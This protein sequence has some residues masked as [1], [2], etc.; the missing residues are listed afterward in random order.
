MTRTP[1]ASFPDDE[2]LVAFVDGR[3]DAAR[4]ATV[5]QRLSDDVLL[6][7]RVDL[8]RAGSPDLK[9]AFRPMLND[10]PAGLERSLRSKLEPSAQ[11]ADEFQPSRRKFALGLLFAG[12]SSGALGYF[13]GR[14]QHSAGLALAD[15]RKDV[16]SYHTFYGPDTIRRLTPSLQ[17]IDRE[18]E[19]VSQAIGRQLR[20]IDQVLAGYA[21]KRA[22]ILTFGG[23]PLIQIVFATPDDVAI[24]F[25]M[26]RSTVSQATPVMSRFHDLPL[27]SWTRDGLDELVV[28]GLPEKELLAIAKALSNRA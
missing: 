2:L 11:Q 15:W 27:A 18:L 24:A 1:P 25:C 26:K 5:E 19:I 14:N 8:L 10:V 4:H 16:A 13:G 6:R 23:A 22:Q 12:V 17:E 3:L 21:Y 20:G 28:A 7:N 9:D